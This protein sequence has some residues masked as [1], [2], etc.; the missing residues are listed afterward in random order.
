MG[1]DPAAGGE[2]VEFALGLL[3]RGA[4]GFTYGVREIIL[5]LHML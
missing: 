5:S 4:V 1:Q 3:L 2:P